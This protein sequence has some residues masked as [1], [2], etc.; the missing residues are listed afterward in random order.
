M[1][2]TSTMTHDEAVKCFENA[3]GTIDREILLE[4]AK[5]LNI[6]FSHDVEF[7]YNTQMEQNAGKNKHPKIVNVY[8]LFEEDELFAS[9]KNAKSLSLTLFTNNSTGHIEI[10]NKDTNIKYELGKSGIKKTFSKNVPFEKTNTA[11]ILKEIGEE[12]I[13]FF[14]TKNIGDNEVLYHHFLTPV[15]LYNSVCISFI[16]I[17][18]KEYINYTRIDNKFYYHQFEYLESKKGIVSTCPVTK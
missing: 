13:Y 15:K 3:V 18:I 12:G 9:I 7:V 2:N 10:N 5:D 6:K 14:T 4:A 16:R 17:V 8:K 11:N 1:F